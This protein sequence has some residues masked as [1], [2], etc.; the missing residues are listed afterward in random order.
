[1]NLTINWVIKLL[2]CL[3]V[4]GVS[5]VSGAKV[6]FPTMNVSISS[7]QSLNYVVSSIGLKRIQLDVSIT[8]GFSNLS[9]VSGDT[10][11]VDNIDIPNAGTHQ[12]NTLVKFNNTG[13]TELKLVV[14]G[15]SMTISQMTIE[16]VVTSMTIPEYNDVSK[17][18]GLLDEPSLKYGGPSV[19]DMNNDGHYELI[20]NNH[21]DAANKLFWN[22]GNG[23]LTQNNGDL[24]LWNRMDLHGSAAGDYDNDGDL[25]LVIAVGGGN[26]TNPKPPVFYA[27]NNGNLNLS[28][29]GASEVGIAVGARGRSPRWVDFD[30]DGDLD[31]ALFNNG[32]HNFHKNN[33]NGTFSPV[34]VAGL[35]TADGDRVLVTDL[36]N[37]NIDDIVL[38]SP[39]SVWK[40]NGNFTFTNMS[41]TW[42]PSSLLNTGQI[43]AAVDVDIDNDGDFDL[44]L[45]RGTSANGSADFD[46]SQQEVDLR[47]TGNSGRTPF[48]VS[49][50]GSLVL[51]DFET[52]Y[53]STYDGD[54]PL[55]LGSTKQ[56]QDL[57]NTDTTF[58]ITRGAAAGWA[59]SREENGLYIGYVGDDKWQLESVR[60]DNIYWS[61]SFTLFGVND[62]SANWQPFNRNLQDIL[63]RNDG[64]KFVEVSKDWNIPVGGNHWGVT[65]GDFNNDGFNDLYV[66]RFAFVKHRVSDYFLLNTGDNRFELTTHHQANNV[67]ARSHGDMGQAFDFDL[68]G[69]V[70]ILSGDNEYG[71]WHLY[72]NNQV[73]GNY[74]IVKVGYSPLA[75]VDPI[76]AEIILTTSSGV[77][78]KRVGSS[79]A[80]YSQSLLN[81]VHFGLGSINSI[82][83]VV[84]RWRNG[85]TQSM[86]NVGINQVLD[87]SAPASNSVSIVQ[88]PDNIQSGESFNVV[89]SYE[90]S[91]QY[92]L[93]ALVN[94]PNGTWLT[95][96][97][98][99]VNPGKGSE[100]LTISQPS[101]WLAGNNYQLGVVIRPIGGDWPTNLDHKTKKFNVVNSSN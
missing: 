96:T 13:N 15:E 52:V 27:N 31:L 37:D 45:A 95:N 49:T 64:N 73:G 6:T 35:E 78:R 58:T 11:L 62:F 61:I 65:A 54:F 2:F 74:A 21:N 82:E 14:R 23:T 26:G 91:A 70:D 87:T 75:N 88:A 7:P 39:L 10:I 77:F 32:L 53:R 81:M 89:I 16:D 101:P 57:A 17:E 55:F 94:G 36:N 92:Q 90:S 67:G 60:N 84:I 18:I 28:S 86:T 93:V 5:Q 66:Y 99:T 80:A 41:N 46:I 44:Y 97:K 83:S 33:G 22:N 51:K 42:L 12:L 1:M 56:R 85:E 71:A 38:F 29:T 69:D 8:K 48:E 47:L 72:Q 98:K 19:A 9:I 50:S 25:D 68:D 24:A 63:L 20:L 59:Q 4:I 34:N 79:G 76:S 43:L 40:G 100:T 3:V 30:L